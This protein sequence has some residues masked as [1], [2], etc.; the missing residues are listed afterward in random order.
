[1]AEITVIELFDRY[2][3]GDRDFRGLDLSGLEFFGSSIGNRKFITRGADFTGANMSQC[4]F[5]AG[6]ASFSGGIFRS[7]DFTGA[8][9]SDTGIRDCDMSFANFTGANF[10]ESASEGVNFEGA[11]FT[12]AV[13]FQSSIFELVVTGAIFRGAKLEESGPKDGRLTR[14][15]F[16]EA[17]MFT[18]DIGRR[19]II[20]DRTIMPD[21]SIRT[22]SF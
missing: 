16:T 17:K 14:V 8:E 19:N 6:N 12:N 21:G 7:V 13:F 11:N 9:F 10:G 5:L 3:A 18:L 2:D 15:D 1:M 22:D 4:I 20:F